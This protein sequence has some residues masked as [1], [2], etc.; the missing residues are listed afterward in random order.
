MH[1]VESL[2]VLAIIYTKKV[3]GD[4]KAGKIRLYSD[5]LTVL[6]EIDLGLPQLEKV[7]FFPDH[8]SLILV[9]RTKTAHVLYLDQSGSE[10]D[11]DFA[12]VTLNPLE[13]KDKPKAQRSTARSASITQQLSNSHVMVKLRSIQQMDW[14]ALNVQVHH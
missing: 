1:A 14:T 13:M 7:I 2:S 11:A 8:N 9:D 6:Q 5:F 10:I 3:T 12:L 4:T